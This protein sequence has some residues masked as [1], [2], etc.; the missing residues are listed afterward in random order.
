MIEILAGV[1]II[2][3]FCLVCA[4]IGE[5]WSYL[6]EGYGCEGFGEAVFEGVQVVVGTAAVLFVAWM[7]GVGLMMWVS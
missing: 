4:V 6:V 3:L 2:A 5:A 7:L 1:V